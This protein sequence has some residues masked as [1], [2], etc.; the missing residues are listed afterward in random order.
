VIDSGSTDETIAI[1]NEFTTAVYFRTWTGYGDQ[2]NFALSLCRSDWVLNV[3]AD[4]EVSVELRNAILEMLA[5]DDSRIVGYSLLR[6]VRFLDLW[7]YAGYW[8]PEY[9]LRL[10]RRQEFLWSS[11]P[12]HEKATINGKKRKL[13]GALYHYTYSDL[14]HQVRRI[15]EYSSLM[16]LRKFGDIS[17]NEVGS[18]SIFFY[19][20]IIFSL[21]VRPAFR[22]IRFYIIKRGFLYGI[23]G[24][25]VAVNDSYY[26]FLKYAKIWEK[27]TQPTIQNTGGSK[28]GRAKRI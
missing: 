8:Y 17:Q 12:V 25:V 11:D 24:L 21:I 7:W 13:K 18:P 5:S 10:G 28:Y 22:F 9:R 3:D 26:V 15:N 23:A 27:H 14:E 20:W 6:V 1:T 4:E 19:L 2:K 16:A